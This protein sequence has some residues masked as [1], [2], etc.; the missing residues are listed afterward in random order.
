MELATSAKRWFRDPNVSIEEKRFMVE[1]IA[2]II[3][4]MQRHRISHGD[5]K[6]SNI[7]IAD[8][9]A[10]VIDLDATRHHKTDFAF[11][12]AW[13]RDIRRFLQNWEDDEELCGLFVKSLKSHGVESPSLIMQQ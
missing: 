6:A 3:R 1:Q 2:R 5:L 9:K 4:G 10:M 8:D 7:L 12:R 11:R 13:A